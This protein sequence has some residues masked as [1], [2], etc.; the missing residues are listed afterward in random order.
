MKDVALNESVEHLSCRLHELVV[1]KQHELSWLQTHFQCASKH[2]L[3][4]MER[5]ITEKLNTIMASQTDEAKRV[6]ALTEQVTKIGTESRTLLTRIEELLA[7]IAAGGEATPELT[8]AVDALKA[9]V[10]V[11]DDLVPDAVP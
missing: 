2:D 9:Q 3:T 8:A 4:E 5:R 1:Q 6:T 10:Q 7:V 11:V